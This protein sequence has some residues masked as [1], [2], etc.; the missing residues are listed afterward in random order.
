MEKLYVVTGDVVNSRNIEDRETFKK[1]FK[2]SL[3]KIN[4]KYS[5]DIYMPILN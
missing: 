5:Q 2:K 1:T 3:N 4:N